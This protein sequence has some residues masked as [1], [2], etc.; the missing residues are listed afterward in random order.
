MR[1]EEVLQQLRAAKSAHIQWRARAQALVAGIEM[2][3]DKIPIIHTD[4]KFGQW[5][6]GVGQKMAALPSFKAVETPHE[7]LHDIY[8]KIF[9]VLHGEDERSGWQK[10]F[11]KQSSFE[12]AQLVK[13]KEYLKEL[14]EISKTLLTAIDLLENDIK[15]IN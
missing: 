15:A 8:M 9:K 13:A 4:C 11:G 10:L 6:Y 2:E 12:D 5:Y 1:K 7:I 3:K 14:V